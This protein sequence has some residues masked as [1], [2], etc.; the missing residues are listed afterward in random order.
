MV[1]AEAALDP[2]L[3][4][5]GAD[6][7]ARAKEKAGEGGSHSAGTRTSARKG[8]GPA[9]ITGDLRRAVTHELAGAHA[10]RIGAAD[11]PHRAAKPGWKAPKAT[12][13]QIGGY[14][15]EKGFPWLV[16]AVDEVMAVAGAELGDVLDA[17]LRW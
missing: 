17:E 2:V 1:A 3:M 14:V 9:V 16:P 12:A 8:S 13:G 7:E 6:C 11:I 5:L 10:V 4:K 15:A